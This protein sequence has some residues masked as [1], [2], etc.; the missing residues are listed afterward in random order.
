MTCKDESDR[1]MTE[2]LHAGHRFSGNK[3]RKVL[4]MTSKPV[5]SSV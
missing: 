4:L 1:E 3:K 5:L 2:K